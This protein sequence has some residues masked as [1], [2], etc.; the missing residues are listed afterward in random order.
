MQSGVWFSSHFVF[1][2][3]FFMLLSMT[4]SVLPRH[5]NSCETLT[6]TRTR[7]FSSCSVMLEKFSLTLESRV[8]AGCRSSWQQGLE[9]LWHHTDRRWRERWCEFGSCVLC[10][11]CCCLFLCGSHCCL[12]L[13]T[14]TQTYHMRTLMLMSLGRTLY[15]F[16]FNS[17]RLNLML[18]HNCYM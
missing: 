16:S 5:T 2:L 1:L 3:F 12:Q 8:A 7:T 18:H 14:L 11:F 15:W 13:H 4:S 6:L 9:P 17:W 10:K